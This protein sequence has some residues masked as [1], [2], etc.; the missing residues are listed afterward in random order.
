[1]WDEE[2]IVNFTC[3]EVDWTGIDACWE[4]INVEPVTLTINGQPRTFAARTLRF[5][6]YDLGYTLDS[7]QITYPRMTYTLLHRYAGWTKRV[8][9]K[10][11]NEVV[12]GVKKPILDAI[13]NPITTPVYLDGHGAQLA[14]GQ[15]VVTIGVEEYPEVQMGTLLLWDVGT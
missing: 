14:V 7:S 10:G 1:L 9:D 2:I 11:L 12:G 6:R 15:N 3:A 5:A 13:G 4:S 8:A